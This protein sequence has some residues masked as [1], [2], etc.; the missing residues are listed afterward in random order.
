M[1]SQAGYSRPDHK[2]QPPRTDLTTLS[3]LAAAER[4]DPAVGLTLPR[5]HLKD[6]LTAPAGRHIPSKAV[7]TAG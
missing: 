1:L 3:D 7:L 5:A 2:P 4:L 6:T